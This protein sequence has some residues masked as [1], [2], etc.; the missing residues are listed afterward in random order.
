MV[1][2]NIPIER[3]KLISS[4]GTATVAG[5][6]LDSDQTY[7]GDFSIA[8]ADNAVQDLKTLLVAGGSWVNGAAG[9]IMFSSIPIHVL[10]C[11]ES[12]PS[13]ANFKARVE[14]IPANTSFSAG[15]VS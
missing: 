4:T 6:L 7:L 15:A 12:L 1:V 3:C 2:A 9:A 10:A 8:V 14:S 13:V 5:V 11:K